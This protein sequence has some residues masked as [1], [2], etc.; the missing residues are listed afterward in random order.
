MEGNK[1][2]MRRKKHT[3]VVLIFSVLVFILPISVIAKEAKWRI[4]TLVPEIT[5]AGAAMYEFAKLIEERTDGQIK[6]DC[7]PVQQLGF[8][9][10]EFD[11][12]AKGVQEMGFI[13]PSARYKELQANFIDF[14]LTD[15]DMV[16]NYLSNKEG[17]MF[18]YNE[19][20]CEQMGI[21]VLGLMNVGFEGYSGM[22]GPVVY[23]EDITKLKIKTRVGYP[24]SKLYYEELGPVVSIDMAEVF[25]ALQLGVVDCQANQAVETVYTQFHD[26]TKYFTDINSLP[27]IIG[28]LINQQLY[29]S[30]S[31]EIQEILQVT[32]DEIVKKVNEE[33]KAKEEYYYQKFEEEGVIVT[34]LTPEQREVWAERA[35]KPGGMWD[36]AREL[37]GDET[38]DFL[39]KNLSE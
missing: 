3:L 30:L 10:D 34:R 5:P 35:R 20:N 39:I 6:M 22:K 15:W 13:P 7:Y 2:I 23:P 16:E 27:A 14:S 8:W 17:F 18:K 38:I 9:M 26:V 19:K 36:K 28:I 37:V 1:Y 21:K 29:N 24:P 12:I 32:A 31:P 4:G 11:N 25:T 33:S